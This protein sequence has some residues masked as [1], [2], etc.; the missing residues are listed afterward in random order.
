MGKST[1]AHAAG[2]ASPDPQP[3]RSARIAQ[4]PVMA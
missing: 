1:A 3:M 2:R 4:I